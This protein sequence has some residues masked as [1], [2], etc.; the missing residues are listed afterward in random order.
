ML[1]L[2]ELSTCDVEA[3]AGKPGALE[4]SVYPELRSRVG[5]SPAAGGNVGHLCTC[6]PVAPRSHPDAELSGRQGASAPLPPGEPEAWQWAESG[7]RFTAL[8]AVEQGQLLRTFQPRALLGQHALSLTRSRSSS[9]GSGVILCSSSHCVARGAWPSSRRA[10]VSRW[11][12]VRSRACLWDVFPGP[13]PW[14]PESRQALVTARHG[15]PPPS[16]RPA[17]GIP[18]SLPQ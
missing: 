14:D 6:W 17:S 5:D 13:A 4:K 8:A 2:V 3:A 11:G 9:L 1:R 16:S 10:P 18:E 12:R 7:S 15:W